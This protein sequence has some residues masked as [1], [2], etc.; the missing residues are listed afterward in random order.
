M[1]NIADRIA[2][3]ILD[4]YGDGSYC[5]LF[6]K[7][8]HPY[9]K[10]LVSDSCCA[11]RRRGSEIFQVESQGEIRAWVNVPARFNTVPRKI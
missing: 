3:C 4:A 6:E 1:R 11:T 7:P 8:Q 2:V 10:M 9:T 5:R